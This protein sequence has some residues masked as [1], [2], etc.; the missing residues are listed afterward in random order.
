MNDLWSIAFLVSVLAAAVPAGTAL[1]Y[2]AMGETFAE[3]A[4]LLNLGV[5][6]MRLMGALAGFG[7]MTWSGNALVGAAGAILAGA[8]MAAIH[9][10]LT[11]SL[12]ANQVVSGLALTLFGTGLS[13]YLGRD[14]VGKRAA[15]RFNSLDVPL[16]SE[17]PHLGRIL[18][19][20]NLLVYASYFFVPL[21][22]WYVYRTRQGLNLRALGERPEAADSLGLNV[23]SL[24]YCYVILGGAL[25]GI[26]GAVFSL[27]T[28]PG[29]I[30]G[31]TAG[32][33]WIAV[34]L[35]IFA[36][37]NP[38]RIAAGAWLFGGVEASVPRL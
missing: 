27:G 25:A 18:F 14:L 12:R 28:N 24:R 36:G 13:A 19:Q 7:I 30:E 21:C 37:W 8:V 34:A 1:L 16:L 33:G 10:F 11:V 23:N 22:W 29:W 26:G 17:I 9:A 32:A 3:R 20:Q 35:V 31:M 5:E 4:G 15:D 38:L 2:A 6:G